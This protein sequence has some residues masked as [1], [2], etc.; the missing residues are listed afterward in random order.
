[1][2]IK[3]RKR[4]KQTN[5]EI[6]TEHK[7]LPPNPEL[8]KYIKEQLNAGHKFGEIREHLISSGWSAQDIESAFESDYQ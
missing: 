8:Q 3:E 4:S 5:I 6:T 1:M 7:K 2:F